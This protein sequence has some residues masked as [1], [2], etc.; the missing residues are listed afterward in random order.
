MKF[1]LLVDQ[2][3]LQ[4]SSSEVKHLFPVG[5]GKAK[6]S[7][8][9]DGLRFKFLRMLRLGGATTAAIEYAQHRCCPGVCNS[10]PPRKDLHEQRQGR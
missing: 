3:F 5:Q 4:K 1:R 2:D 9:D 8:A 7:Y 10:Q 6:P